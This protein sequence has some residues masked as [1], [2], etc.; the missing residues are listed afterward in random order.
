MGMT[1]RS[2]RTSDRDAVCLPLVR[3]V[4]RPMAAEELLDLGLSSTPAA[5]R[6]ISM[7]QLSAS[8][9]SLRFYWAKS[10]YFLRLGLG[11][12]STVDRPCASAVHRR[13]WCRP[14][15]RRLKSR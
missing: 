11:L 5:R 7:Y 10:G 8:G 15:C 13:P 2:A 3:Q 4:L 12:V 6:G 1:A 14:S 9:R